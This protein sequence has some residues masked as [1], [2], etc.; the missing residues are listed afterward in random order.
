MRLS[1]FVPAVAV[2]GL[3]A[4][5]AYLSATA[6]AAWIEAISTDAVEAEMAKEGLD[7]VSVQA[8]GLQLVLEGQ[9]PNEAARFAAVSH[10]GRVVDAARLLD[11]MSVAN[12]DIT[13]APEF[14]IEVLRNDSGIT[15]IGLIPQD[16][17][18]DRYLDRIAAIA[19]D[20]QVFDFLET[21]NYPTPPEWNASTAYALDAIDTL[22]RAKITVLAGQVAIN[23][24]SESPEQRRTFE[25][26][27]ARLKPA[28]VKAEFTISAPRPVITP[29]TL[30]IIRDDA[31]VRFNACSADTPSAV[32]KI[33][34]AS[35][36]AGLDGKFN[37]RLGL[38]APSPK[39]GDAAAQAI[40]ALAQ[41]GHGTVT[42]SD[43]DVT[44]VAE[45]GTDQATFDK[46]TS[47][48]KA[49]LPEAFS[50]QS[51]I[52]QE[53]ITEVADIPKE[54]IATL[55]PEGQLQFRGALTDDLARRSVLVFAGAKFSG[56]QVFDAT[57]N[58]PDLAGSWPVRVMTGLDGLSQL[59]SGFIEITPTAISLSGRTGDETA[60]DKISTALLDKLGRDV[61]LD[62]NITYVQALD[63]VANR[64]TPGECVV[65]VNALI[66]ANKITFEPGSVNLDP[67][68]RSTVEEIATI[69][70]RCP[71][72]RIEIAGHTDSQGR[73][74]MN[75]NLSKSRA[76]AVLNAL[77]LH[78]VILEDVSAMGYGETQ[79]IAD[80]GTPE[81]REANRRIEFRLLAETAEPLQDPTQETTNE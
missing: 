19:G 43:A 51:S 38:G 4:G 7:W 20:A 14:S 25:A 36:E 74:E 15:L 53:V 42:L 65:Q 57:K 55:S 71:D 31:G 22:E 69:L 52:Q 68:S 66:E 76:N 73:E 32:E 29:F 70:E 26:R 12:R 9:A 56:V 21:A 78:R 10:A 54:F 27:L 8:D 28:Q 75:L 37:C 48:L 47:R 49:R 81:G 34:L 24:I 41:V 17:D 50:L 63:P 59:D 11:S 23:G 79:P 40:S 60:K 30:Q 5:G 6:G 44:L 3:A 18:K 33:Q 13:V 62:L 67:Q 58:N 61:T 45:T 2:F 72:A 77:M 39:W 80:N 35:I 64:L 1:H 16:M 46:V